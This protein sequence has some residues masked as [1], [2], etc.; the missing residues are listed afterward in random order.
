MSLEST[1]WFS[2]KT[3]FTRET[4]AKRLKNAGIVGQPGPKAS[5]LYESK[6]AFPILYGQAEGGEQGELM[7]ART[8]NLEADTALK[9][10]KE[11]QL[12]G[13]LAPI[14]VLE[15][16][17]SSV[18]NQIGA[19]LETLPAKLKRRLPQLNA[20]DLEIIRKEVA[21]TRNAAAAVRLDLGESY[22]NAAFGNDSAG[23]DR[24]ATAD[25]AEV[26]GVGG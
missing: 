2:E 20:A 5:L 21:K 19:V 1:S 23:A 13:E 11:Q 8:E 4:V 9:R 15:W 25:A 6:E 22:E 10:L 12:L 16:T 24:A 17:L 3:G 14:S 18:C 7:K 26:V